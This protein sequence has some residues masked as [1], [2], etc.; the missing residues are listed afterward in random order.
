MSRFVMAKHGF[1]L[2]NTNSTM[3]KVSCIFFLLISL[4]AH[5]QSVSGYWY[6]FANVKGV[7][8][9][10]N[11]ML[12][13]IL[14]PEQGYVKGIINYYFKNTYRS[15]QVKGN[16]DKTTR[17]LSLYN[18]PIPFYG[19]NANMEIDCHM[20]MR[21]TLRVAKTASNLTGSFI[22]LPE[23]KYTCAELNVDLKLNSDISNQDSVLKAI[24]EYKEQYQVWQPSATDTA[25][26]ATIIQRKVIN[27]FIENEYKKRENEVVQEIEVDTDSLQ[28]DFYDNGEVD[29]DS[30]SV[31]FNHQLIAFSQKLTTR[32][33][34]FD[35]A[36]DTTKPVNEITMFADNLGSIPPNT[37]LMI[38]TAGGKQYQVR[39]SSNLEKN[40]TLRI[41]R[42]NRN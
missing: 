38:V 12:E 4:Y 2:S 15:I 8:S 14:Q 16:F 1:C 5:S 13:M 41:R 17:Q 20:N 39:L 3:K 22:S 11:Y 30:I 28:L 7:S 10:N 23:Y 40:A 31:F 6:G 9:A 24:R 35:I 18:I 19:S 36:L 32:S 21:T 26:A 29:G 33:I 42:K 27:Y 25:V 37:A 34:H